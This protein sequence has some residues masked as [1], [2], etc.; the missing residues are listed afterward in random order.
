MLRESGPAKNRKPALA[1]ACSKVVANR[2]D[3]THSYEHWRR[4][5][6]SRPSL[7]I[8]HLGLATRVPHRWRKDG[9]FLRRRRRS[10]LLLAAGRHDVLHSHVGDQ[11]AVVLEVVHVVDRER[12]ESRGVRAEKL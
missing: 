4:R 12:A 5:L 9:L 8:T 1:Q 6:R 3:S 11:V 2:N 7:P 10:R